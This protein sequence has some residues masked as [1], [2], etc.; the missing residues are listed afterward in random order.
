MLLMMMKNEIATVME[1]CCFSLATHGVFT[2]TLSNVN[3]SSS[4]RPSP[5]DTATTPHLPRH[6]LFMP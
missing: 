4:A 5:N 2:E 1:V 6:F 3:W